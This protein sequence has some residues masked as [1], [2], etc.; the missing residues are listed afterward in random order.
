MKWYIYS[1][2][3]KMKVCLSL[4]A[5]GTFNDKTISYSMSQSGAPVTVHLRK[6]L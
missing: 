6:C 3:K 1:K 4:L 2:E 5:T